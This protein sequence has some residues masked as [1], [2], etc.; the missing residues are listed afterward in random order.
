[1]AN[2]PKYL[3][4]LDLET[5]GTDEHQDSIIEVG[6]VLCTLDLVEVAEWDSIVMPTHWGGSRPVQWWTDGGHWLR[7]LMNEYVAGMHTQNGLINELMATGADRKGMADFWFGVNGIQQQLERWLSG[8]GKR[9]EFMLAGSGVSHFDRRFL[10]A[11]LPEFEKWL[12]YPNM[13]VGV[14]RRFATLLCGVD[15]P[16]LSEGKTHR[17]LDDARIHLQEMRNWRAF[18]E[19][20]VS[21]VK[22]GPG[23]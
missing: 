16:D 9:H 15:V 12:Q 3:V 6:I 5:T 21:A 13:D 2:D 14:V 1:M 8:Y 4:V 20:G 7:S 22:A 17:A 18:I 19:N 23:R 10:K 11:Q